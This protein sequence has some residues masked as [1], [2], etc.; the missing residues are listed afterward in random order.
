MKLPHHVG[1][2]IMARIGDLAVLSESPG[3]LTRRYLT[4]EHRQANELVG[5]WMRDAGMNVH[6]DAIG[7]IVGRYEGVS[8]SLPA[9][10]IGSHLDTVVMAGRYDGMLGVL[11]GIACV[12]SLCERGIRLPFAVEVVGFADEE[13]ARFQSTYLGSRALAGTFDTTLLERRD[14]DGISMAEALRAFGLDPGRIGDAARKPEDVAAYLELH[15]EQGPVLESE[16]LAVGVVTA[17]AGAT[18]LV[19]TVAGV[20][21]HAGTVPMALRQD[22][23]MAASECVLA[24]EKVAAARSNGV[25]TVG[26]MRVE[27]GATNVIPGKVTFSVDL[28]AAEDEPRKAAVAELDSRLREIAA[29]RS[30]DVSVETVHEAASITCAP[31]IVEQIDQ[32]IEE[33]GE[34]V[35]RL[36]SGAGHDAAAMA[37]ITDVGMI[38]LRC[39]GGISHNPD[40]SITQDDASA[41]T[42]LLLKII[43]NFKLKT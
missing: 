36:P 11:T 15:I 25:G 29:R 5:G 35:F 10:I 1:A 17:I 6:Q 7:N 39:K 22:A 2:G 20:A 33:Q 8:E 9:L 14:G 43:E 23:L 42:S 31:R 34:R 30:V 19:V 16:G 38:F 12:Q 40:E 3:G 13:G 18:R 32:A 41:G 21:G 27:P 24:V 26:R 37:D 4:T 28:R